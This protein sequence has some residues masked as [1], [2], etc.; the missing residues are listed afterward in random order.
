MCSR[1]HENSY[2]GL[3]MASPMLQVQPPVKLRTPGYGEMRWCHGDAIYENHLTTNNKSKKR[4][5][6]VSVSQNKRSTA[7][8]SPKTVLKAP[9]KG[10][11]HID[12]KKRI[13][14]HY[15]P[16]PKGRDHINN[17]TWW[18]TSRWTKMCQ[19]SQCDICHKTINAM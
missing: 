7:L 1:T 14:A 4:L 2:D 15:A 10:A 3:Q 18:E 16:Q 8:Y 19:Q 9:D 5:T 6:K 17:A 12:G 13:K 11:W